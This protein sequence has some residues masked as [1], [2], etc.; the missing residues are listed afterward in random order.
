[1]SVQ[2]TQQTI[3]TTRYCTSCVDNGTKLDKKK[4]HLAHDRRSDRL[5]GDFAEK[6]N[7]GGL[8][9]MG[10]FLKTPFFARFCRFPSVSLVVRCGI[11]RFENPRL[12]GR[13]FCAPFSFLRD[14]S[15]HNYHIQGEK[16]R[17]RT[18]YICYS[19]V[20]AIF[21]SCVAMHRHKKNEFLWW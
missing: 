12:F 11:L 2:T 21:L 15:I 19:P 6:K 1:M 7:G 13:Y 9:C 4:Q 14:E 16:W 5:L 8:L 18:K 10:P 3:R 17:C 20:A